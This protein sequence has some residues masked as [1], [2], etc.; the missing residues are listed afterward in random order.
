[1]PVSKNGVYILF[2]LF[3][4]LD[5]FRI[6]KQ[7]VRYLKAMGLMVPISRDLLAEGNTTTAMG[8]QQQEGSASASS[9]YDSIFSQLKFGYEGEKTHSNSDMSLKTKTKGKAG[10]KPPLSALAVS[11][12]ALCYSSSETPRGRGCGP[13]LVDVHETN[14]TYVNPL[15][16]ALPCVT[17]GECPYLQFR[18]SRGHVWKAVPGS[19]VCFH[20]PICQ[21]ARKVGV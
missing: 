10:T 17:D 3:H 21:T 1:M 5:A 14:T 16:A 8:K 20:C 7:P 11:T 4:L 19:P 18:C 12:T 13:L 9:A 2:V 15:N 6:D